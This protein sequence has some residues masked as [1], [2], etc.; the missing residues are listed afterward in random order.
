MS[1]VERTIE[2]YDAI[3]AAY[4]VIATPEHRTWLEGSMREFHQR[5]PGRSVLVPGCGEGR[6][7]RYLR[8][9]GAEVTSFDLSTGMLAIARAADPAGNYLQLDLR[10]VRS[11][12]RTFD[13]V[14]A[15]ACLYHLR[16][17]EFRACLADFRLLLNERGVVFLNLKLGR[18]ERFIDVPRDGFPG[19][20]AAQATLAGRRFYA[21]Y[22]RDE[23]TEYF[24]GYTVETERRDLLQEGDGAMEFW[25]R[26]D[27]GAPRPGSA[28]R[29]VTFHAVTPE[30]AEAAELIEE[31]S[32]RLTA[33]TGSTGKGSFSNTDMSDPRAILLVAKEDGRP[34]ACGALRPI[35]ERTCELKRMYSRRSRS[36]HGSLLLRELEH[37]ANLRGFERIWVETRKVN[38]GAVAFYSKH[39]YAVIPNYGKYAGNPLAICFEKELS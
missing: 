14:W 35:D 26:K 10:E 16:K 18:G 24:A 36:G 22:N 8:T 38:D 39:G 13:G 3:A 12:G 34:V 5:I 31:L 6:D 1:H 11:L 7:S 37:Q 19:G 17:D 2:T 21:F 20:S 27:R 9:L 15:C 23:L 30:D 32:A 28:P 29:R 25:L 33:I 4:H